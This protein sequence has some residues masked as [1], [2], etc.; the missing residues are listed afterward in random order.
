MEQRLTWMRMRRRAAGADYTPLDS[1]CHLLEYGAGGRP[2]A[3]M[4]GRAIAAA[5]TRYGT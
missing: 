4:L 5:R 2:P 1:E 3:A